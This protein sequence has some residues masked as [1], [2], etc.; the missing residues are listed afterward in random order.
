MSGRGAAFGGGVWTV[1]VH[2]DVRPGSTRS[3]MRTVATGPA[4]SGARTVGTHFGR[5]P[6]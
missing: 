4:R 2:F 3:R 5:V 1:A 6:A